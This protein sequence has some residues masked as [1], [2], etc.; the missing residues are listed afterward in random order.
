MPPPGTFSKTGHRLIP[1]SCEVAAT[2]ATGAGE[3]ALMHDMQAY[4]EA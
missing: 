2:A 3:L 4:T 1:V